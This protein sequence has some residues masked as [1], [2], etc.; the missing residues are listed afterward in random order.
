M[1]MRTSAAMKAS[2]TSAAAISGPPPRGEVT[3]AHPDRS[4]HREPGEMALFL[5]LATPESVLTMVAGVL[6]AW[7]GDRAVLAELPGDGLPARSG[8]RTLGARG[9]EQLR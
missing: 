9:E 8:L 2:T 6:P 7:R 4:G 5:G 1:S 3:S